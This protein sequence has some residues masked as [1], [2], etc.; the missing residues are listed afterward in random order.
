[1][2]ANIHTIVGRL[3]MK[4]S[5]KSYKRAD[6]S[7]GTR[8]FFRVMVTRLSDL[9]KPQDQRRVSALPVVTWGNLAKRCAQYLDKGTEVTVVGE[10]IQE[11]RQLED[12]SYQE[13]IQIQANS[14]QF[15]RRSL[16]NASPETLKSQIDAIQASLEAQAS[17]HGSEAAAGTPAQPAESDNPFPS[18]GQA[19]A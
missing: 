14:V 4:P 15:G 17:G 10:V 9:G 16:K 8:C 3:G 6:G 1:M 12:G 19:S 7:E 5:V 2:N 18:L 11:R 13:F